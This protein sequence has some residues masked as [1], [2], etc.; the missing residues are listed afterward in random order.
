MIDEKQLHILQHSLGV[1]RYGQGNQYRNHFCTSEGTVDFPDCMR[2]VE[3][4]LMTRRKG[5][6]ITGGDDVFYVTP[7]GIDYVALHS[8]RPPPPTKKSR[9]KAR[10]LRYLEYGDGFQ[11]F[12]EFLRWDGD[13]AR[14]WNGGAR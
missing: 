8:P 2:L 10:Y 6:A 7:E 9:S 11:N 5:S 14:E 12:R 3:L 13:P 1:D 4:R